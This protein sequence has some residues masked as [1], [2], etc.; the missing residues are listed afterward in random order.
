ML[1]A[2]APDKPNVVL[3]LADDMRADDLKHTPETRS[4][5]VDEGVTFEN[6]CVTNS[7][8]CPSRATIL[9]GQYAH[10]HLIRDNKPSLDGWPVFRDRKREYSTLATWLDD[11]GYETAL[12]G[13]YM[14]HYRGSY[15]P[16]GWD[17]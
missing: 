12:V 17:R 16:P 7:L 15:V 3:I 11:A 13:K 6:A 14:N 8:C 9:R 5:L 10:N 1:G 2:P 4:L